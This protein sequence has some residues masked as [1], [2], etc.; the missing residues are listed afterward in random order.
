[1]EALSF[2]IPVIATDVGGTGEL[3]APTWGELL[4]RELGPDVLAESLIRF[5]TQHVGDDAMR[6]RARAAWAERAS[7][8][9]YGEVA[10]LLA[11]LSRGTDAS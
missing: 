11:S 10:A 9:N 8:R 5:A 4:P 1:M 2:G 7:T 6:N 3:V